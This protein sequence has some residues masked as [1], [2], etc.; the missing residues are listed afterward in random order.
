MNNL[1]K[2]SI[3]ELEQ[4]INFYYQKY[5][6]TRNVEYLNL[7]NE[8]DELLS[9]TNTEEQNYM[10]ANA[11]PS[12]PPNDPPR[13]ANASNPPNDPPRVATA[14]IPPNDPPRVANTS[15]LIPPNDP[16]N[17]LDDSDN[18]SL[19]YN[20]YEEDFNNYCELNYA[21]HNLTA[22]KY[23]SNLEYMF[24]NEE[25][26]IFFNM[27]FYDALEELQKQNINEII[28]VKGIKED[29]N[30]LIKYYV[31]KNLHVN[32]MVCS[33]IEFIKTNDKNLATAYN[34]FRNNKI[35]DSLDL[36]QI[37][38]NDELLIT[39]EYQSELIDKNFFIMDV[40]KERTYYN[41][42]DKPQKRLIYYRT[43]NIDYRS[44]IEKINSYKEKNEKGR[45]R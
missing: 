34:Y 21:I 12:S 16:S 45:I 23:S 29:T 15:P 33:C 42:T 44:V 22:Q 39:T 3:E 24:D 14:S 40:E 6:E 27:R 20:N 13:V 41:S 18:Y 32:N 37:N 11:S 1:N 5:N 7:I 8:I 38:E 30:Y 35:E 31:T 2:Y 17:L 19:S 10:N 9:K 25:K 28:I 4:M 26:N 36:E 43:N